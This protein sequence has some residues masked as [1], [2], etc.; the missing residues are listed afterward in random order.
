MARQLS[1]KQ[2]FIYEA[3]SNYNKIRK[4]LET[5][6]KSKFTINDLQMTEKV[7][8]VNKLLSL[9]EIAYDVRDI[10][11]RKCVFKSTKHLKKALE[12]PKEYLSYLDTL[13]NKI[14]V[15]DVEAKPDYISPD[16]EIKTLI[17]GAIIVS[18]RKN[19]VNGI[20]YL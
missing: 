2:L 5:A 1:E 14:K 7:K 16:E 10:N 12:L 4:Y 13:K 18:K 17:P 9:G 19:T 15:V 11:I 8:A 6:N 20:V 3:S